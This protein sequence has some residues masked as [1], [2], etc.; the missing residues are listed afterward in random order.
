MSAAAVAL[1]PSAP[2]RGVW[3]AQTWAMSKRSILAIVRQPAL[4]IPS[5]VFP[6]FFAALGTSSFGKATVLPGF[7]KVN[8]FLDFS[9]AG[10]VVQGVLFGS[11]TGGT[12]LATD[13]ELGFFDRLL[14][15]PTSRV[16]ILLGRL[17]GA[18]AFGA[19]QALF[20]TLILIPFGV[21]IEA[22]VLG[23]LVITLS[24]AL[25]GM[26]IGGFTAAMALKTGSSEAVQG[27]FPLLFIALFFSSAFFPRQ[28]MQGVYRHVA[29]VNPMSYLVEGVRGLT[30]D[31]LTLGHVAG[32]LV[33]PA[34]IGVVSIGLSL[35]ALRGRLAAR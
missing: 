3:W 27:S 34:A 24:G 15:T 10:S 30:I 33:V 22:G 2:G 5:L 13:I 12:A 18:A 26:G 17:A 32:A 28:T 11:V 4:V 35:R 1:V 16:S 6:L 21:T 20:F 25:T 31:G 8:S 7:P 14:A 23:V 29:N 9:L 19:F